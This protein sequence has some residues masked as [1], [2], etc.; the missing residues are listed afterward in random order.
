MRVRL[1]SSSIRYFVVANIH[2]LHDPLVAPSQSCSVFSAA[3]PC[4]MVVGQTLMFKEG[5]QFACRPHPRTHG[6]C[7]DSDPVIPGGP[8]TRAREVRVQEGGGE[9]PW[10]R[11]RRR[12]RRGWRARGRGGPRRTDRHTRCARHAGGTARPPADAAPVTSA[13]KLNLRGASAGS[14]SIHPSLQWQRPR[15]R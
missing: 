4:T 3:S 9:A 1:L 11:R 10:S 7:R 13:P 15:P 6:P 2:K 5:L 12:R 8:G 14:L